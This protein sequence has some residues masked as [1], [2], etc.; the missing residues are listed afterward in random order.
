LI[1]PIQQTHPKIV[2][3]QTTGVADTFKRKG[4]VI[5][6][7]EDPRDHFLVEFFL[8]AIPRVEISLEADDRVFQDGEH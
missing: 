1:T 5:A 8:L 4:S 6:A 7:V 3:F 2:G